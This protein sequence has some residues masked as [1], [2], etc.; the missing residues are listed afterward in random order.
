L[1]KI[2]DFPEFKGFACASHDTGPSNIF[3]FPGTNKVASVSSLESLS[4][5]LRDFTGREL[6][7]EN[8]RPLEWNA[9]HPW[10]STR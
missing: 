10:L 9:W 8:Q 3:S 5:I 7:H 6:T 4:T 1:I 2:R